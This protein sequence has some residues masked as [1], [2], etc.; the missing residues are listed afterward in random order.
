MLNP[1]DSKATHFKLNTTLHCFSIT[2]VKGK[3]IQKIQLP[4]YLEIDKILINL[5]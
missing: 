2:N 5:D 3:D 4:K 1:G